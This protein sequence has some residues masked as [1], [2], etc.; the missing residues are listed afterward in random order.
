MTEEKVH[1]DKK[2]SFLK[3]AGIVGLG[4]V[5]SQVG[6]KKAQAYV[7]GSAPASSVVGT[8]DITNTRIT[9]ATEDGNLASIAA[10]DFATQ[11]TLAQIKTNFDEF[12]FTGNDLRVTGLIDGH[13]DVVQT[14]DAAHTRVGL[15]S[16]DGVVL[17]RRMVKLLESHATVD[18]ANRQRLT[19]DAW[20]ENIS[21]ALDSGTALGVQ[22]LISL[23]DTSKVLSWTENQ[24]MNYAVKI[25]AGT[26]IG[27]LR[28][29][30]SNTRDTLTLINSWTTQPDGT[31]VYGIY[32]VLALTSVEGMGVG[33]QGLLTLA[34]TTKVWTTNQW[35]NF[36]VRITD[37][38]KGGTQIRL[39][40]SNTSTVLT[41]QYPWRP[42]IGITPIAE[43]GI[44]TGQQAIQAVVD[45]SKAWSTDVWAGYAVTI[46]G[47]TGVDQT[48]VI[49]S[50][51]TNT[52]VLVDVWLIQPDSTSTYDIRALPSDAYEYGTASGAPTISTLE[53]LSKAW[54]TNQWATYLV[55]IT[56]GAGANQVAQVASNNATTLTLV[57]AWTIQPDYTSRFV[58]Y[59]MPARTYTITAAPSTLTDVGTSAIVPRVGLGTDSTIGTITTVTSAAAIGFYTAQQR[60][61]DI[62]HKVYNN[63]IRSQL[64]FM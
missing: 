60:F 6:A 24:W 33:A 39:I 61:G 12:Q 43:T 26:G 11:T 55:K 9:S 8:K 59:P 49:A 15:A 35:A 42:K 53:D 31:S 19:F 22:S 29:I 1:D 40:T 5:A 50:N 57:N 63:S 20:M 18:V 48:R 27:Q 13:T 10:E 47:G 62:S 7:F 64:T 51:D 46:T 56:A 28:L 36:V 30:G 32:D 41:Y 2:R 44:A 45:T 4:I 14:Q 37:Q 17:L 3:L 38:E 34:D 52:L 25:T 54:T 16:E 58:L 23:T 21:G